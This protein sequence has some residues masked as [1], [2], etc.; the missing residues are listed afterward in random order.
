MR[1]DAVTSSFSYIDK[2]ESGTLSIAEI[3]IWLRPGGYTPTSRPSSPVGSNFPKGKGRLP[4]EKPGWRPNGSRPAWPLES[5][6]RRERMR[7]A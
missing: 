3:D 6:L 5:G 4:G 2:D 1:R 7:P